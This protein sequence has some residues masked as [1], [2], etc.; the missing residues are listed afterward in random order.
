[1]PTRNAMERCR[2]GKRWSQW[3]KE[4]RPRAETDHFT[5][6]LGGLDNKGEGERI[7]P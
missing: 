1:V 5:S 4:G 3:G 7:K 6:T 2:E